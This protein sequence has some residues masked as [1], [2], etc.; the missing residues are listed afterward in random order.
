MH[1]D[2]FEQR[3]RALSAERQRPAPDRG[4]G[5]LL[6]DLIAALARLYTTPPDQEATH[7]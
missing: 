3:V 7:G 5:E 4:V 6:G 1:R 2:E